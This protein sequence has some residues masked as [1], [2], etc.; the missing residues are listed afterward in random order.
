MAAHSGFPRQCP[1]Q[2]R[3]FSL[4][5]KGYITT[6]YGGSDYK[7]CWKY[8]PAT[9]Q[10]TQIPSFGGPKTSGAFAFVLYDKAY[11][12]GGRN[13]GI[14]V[15][16]FWEFDPVA[17]QWREMEELDTDDWDVTIEFP[18]AF[19][20]NGKGYVVSGLRSFNVK[21]VWEYDP[22][23][24]EWDEM[25]EFEGVARQEAVA[26]VINGRP[27]VTTGRTAGQRYDDIWEF[28]PDQEQDDDD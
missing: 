18:A 5:G 9:D 6:G 3:G 4:L 14:Y 10:W 25:A 11:V 8:D 22:A 1:P 21:T 12:G 13:N 20:L 19:A 15:E 23:R 7:D 28:R 24:D 2:C 17:E 26:F 27:F 16:D